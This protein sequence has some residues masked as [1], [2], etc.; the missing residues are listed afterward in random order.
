[1]NIVL[2]KFLRAIFERPPRSDRLPEPTNGDPH[3]PNRLCERDFARFAQVLNR[4]QQR[5]IRFCFV[6]FI[7]EIKDFSESPDFIACDTSFW[8]L[9]H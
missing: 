7:N 5:H 9:L 8:G 6:K 1:M 4:S 2:P 3:T